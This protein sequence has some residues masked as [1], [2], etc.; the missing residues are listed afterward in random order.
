MG[1]I[2]AKTPSTINFPEYQLTYYK[3]NLFMNSPVLKPF[4]DFHCMTSRPPTVGY[5]LPFQTHFPE[6]SFR[7]HVI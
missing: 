7:K 1:N 3:K 4:T 2:D 6:Y 5:H